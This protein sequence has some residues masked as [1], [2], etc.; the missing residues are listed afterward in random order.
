[1]MRFKGENWEMFGDIISGELS[2]KVF[3]NESR[4]ALDAGAGMGLR[5][6]SVSGNRPIFRFTG[7]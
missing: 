3:S 4:P 1:M 7:S 5:E 2:L 6:A